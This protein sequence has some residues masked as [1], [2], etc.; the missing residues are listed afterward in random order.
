MHIRFYKAINQI[1][2]GVQRR[3]QKKVVGGMGCV[4]GGGGR[5]RRGEERGKL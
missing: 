3:E 1:D 4:C 5:V 2:Q